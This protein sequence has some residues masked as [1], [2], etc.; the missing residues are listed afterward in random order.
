[1]AIPKYQIIENDLIRLIEDGT[2]GHGDRIYSEAELSKKY[3]V[4]SITA[5]RALR[6]LVNQGYLVREQGKGTFVSR[7]RVKQLVELNDIEA[8]SHGE[9]EET[10]QILSF[11]VGTDQ[12]IRRTLALT[13]NEGYHRIVRLRLIGEIP[14]MHTTS[15]IPD[16][17]IPEGVG[18]ERYQSIYRF[19][20]ETFGLELFNEAY[21]ETNEI[22]FP[23]PSD[24]AHALKMDEHEPCAKQCRTT[25][26]ADGR[27][28]EHV[29]SY[30][31]WDYYKIELVRGGNTSKN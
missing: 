10:S 13:D 31:R 3:S 24:V 21:R 27:V 18:V 5:V 11:E 23:L 2:F 28:A 30:K 20:R 6:D 22:A 4:S 16:R 7:G 29:V 9:V 1:M 26:L 17:F 12:E 15:Y 14:F 8:F 25:F 19:F